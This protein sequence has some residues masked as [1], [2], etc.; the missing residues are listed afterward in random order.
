MS[1]QCL[2]VQ[3]SFLLD[4]IAVTEFAKSGVSTKQVFNNLTANALHLSH[5]LIALNVDLLAL[6]TGSFQCLCQLVSCVLLSCC[7]ILNF[8]SDVRIIAT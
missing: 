6:T 4:F 7:S 5:F 1:T 2:G 3:G 8:E